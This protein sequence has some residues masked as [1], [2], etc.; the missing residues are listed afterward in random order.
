MNATPP[1]IF[2]G[3][4]YLIAPVAFFVHCI[5]DTVL[6]ARFH[7]GNILCWADCKWPPEDFTYQITPMSG[8]SAMRSGP[9]RNPANAVSLAT[10]L[11]QKNC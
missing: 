4:P 5:S 9:I 7:P 1:R 2:H 3:R 11:L 10:V 8:F 6:N